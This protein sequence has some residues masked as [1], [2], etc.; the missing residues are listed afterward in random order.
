VV[1][2]LLDFSGLSGAVLVLESL[3]AV[4]GLGDGVVGTAF[5][6]SVSP[7]LLPQPASAR[8]ASKASA[9]YCRIGRIAKTGNVSTG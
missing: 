5:G 7:P 2:H 4:A 6:G 9:R 8:V 3:A 1:R